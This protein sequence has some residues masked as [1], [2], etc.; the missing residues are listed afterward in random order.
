MIKLLVQ[1]KLC[2]FSQSYFGITM[3]LNNGVNILSI[4][5]EAMVD[6]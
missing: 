1:I 3:L 2:I 4:G 5:K 6:L